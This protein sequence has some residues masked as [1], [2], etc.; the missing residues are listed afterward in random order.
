MGALR[1]RS[2][3]SIEPF[4][5]GQFGAVDSDGNIFI[6][7]GDGS[8]R[9]CVDKNPHVLLIQYP[10]PHPVV[11]SFGIIRGDYAPLNRQACDTFYA[12]YAQGKALFVHLTKDF[13]YVYQE[14]IDTPPPARVIDIKTKCDA[15]SDQRKQLIVELSFLDQTGRVHFI[16]YSK[17]LQEYTCVPYKNLSNV[18]E[19]ASHPDAYRI[20]AA[21]KTDGTVV[22]Q[23]AYNPT[24]AVRVPN[25]AEGIKHEQ[26]EVMFVNQSATDSPIIKLSAAQNANIV[27]VTAGRLAFAAIRSDGSAIAWGVATCGGRLPPILEGK[28][29]T[30]SKIVS[31]GFAFAAVFSEGLGQ[32]KQVVVWGMQRLCMVSGE[33]SLSTKAFDDTF[34]NVHD[35][36][37]VEPAVPPRQNVNATPSFHGLRQHAFE[38]F[39]LKGRRG[40]YIKIGDIWYDGGL[41]NPVLVV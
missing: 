9:R 38:G 14:V 28:F 16:E 19:I 20:F 32:P 11:H 23:R 4:D 40:G 37:D 22:T 30:I 26:K 27:S 31:A 36:Y 2:Y 13:N 24:T 6:L 8:L 35:A 1:G 5:D 39:L 10:T 7:P 17:D 33:A 29:V 41:R 21:L 34:D 12:L 25:F 18:A 15:R 3:V